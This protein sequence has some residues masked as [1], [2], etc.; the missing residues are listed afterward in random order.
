MGIVILKFI[1]EVMKMVN[2]TKL[3]KT[4]FMAAAT[5]VGS[6]KACT[7]VGDARAFMADMQTIVELDRNGPGVFA[8]PI[9]A[10]TRNGNAFKQLKIMN[11]KSN[12]YTV[13]EL[14]NQNNSLPKVVAVTDV[15]PKIVLMHA[16]VNREEWMLADAYIH[17]KRWNAMKSLMNRN[18]NTTYLFYSNVVYADV[19]VSDDSVKTPKSASHATYFKYEPHLNR[20]TFVNSHSNF[21]NN[22]IKK[23]RERIQTVMREMFNPQIDMR[24][25]RGNQT[26]KPYCTIHTVLG[27]SDELKGLNEPR[28]RSN[29]HANIKKMQRV[30]LP[31]IRDIVA[32]KPK[33]VD[34][35]LGANAL[36]PNRLNIF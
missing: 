36:Y 33:N 30:M 20:V 4:L 18:P 24:F 14:Q 27:V 17:K 13:A 8:L 16:K 25:K 29:N 22:S 15:F 21:L 1:Y 7:V 31:R 6:Y 19:N 5:T 23:D 35:L 11:K 3:F 26:T 9:T 28:V 10:N 12:V 32:T 34:D 2:L